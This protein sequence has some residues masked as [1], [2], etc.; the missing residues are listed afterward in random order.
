MT[1]DRAKAR[2]QRVQVI[3]ALIVVALVPGIYAGLLTWANEDTTGRLN[4]VPAVIVNA[5]R[6][7]T[8]D[9][10]TTVALGDTLAKELAASTQTNNFSWTVADADD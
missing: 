2:R 3:V 6:P 8:L 7:A 10:G 9:D 1:S 4:Q 5:D